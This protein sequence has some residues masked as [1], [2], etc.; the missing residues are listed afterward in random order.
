LPEP[1]ADLQFK[2][3][4]ASGFFSLRGFLQGFNLGAQTF[5]TEASLIIGRHGN[6]M[7]QLGAPAAAFRLAGH[8]S[9]ALCASF[10]HTTMMKQ[11]RRAVQMPN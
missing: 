4:E 8:G 2:S 7:R 6:H 1:L 9:A 5:F 11:L 3:I 10:F